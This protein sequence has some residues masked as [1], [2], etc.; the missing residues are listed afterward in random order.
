MQPS[1]F[2]WRLCVCAT[3]T[4]RHNQLIFRFAP[5]PPPSSLLFARLFNCKLKRRPMRTDNE[6]DAFFGG[7]PHRRHTNFKNGGSGMPNNLIFPPG[8]RTVSQYYF[9]LTESDPREFFSGGYIEY[10][11]TVIHYCLISYLV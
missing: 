1:H 6:D 10:I 3:T 9:F 5:P 4:P 11:Y 2:A 8:L 7:S